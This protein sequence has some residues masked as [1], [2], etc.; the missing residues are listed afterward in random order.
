MQGTIYKSTGYYSDEEWQDKVLFYR[1]ENDMKDTPEQ[2]IIEAIYEDDELVYGEEKET[3]DKILDGKIL[4]IVDLGRWNGR[5]NGYKVLGNNLNEVMTNF[6]NDDM[7]VFCDGKD[8]RAEAMDHDGTSYFLFREIKDSAN[9]DRLL[10]AIY[11]NED[12]S[13][14]KLSYYTRSLAPYVNSAYGCND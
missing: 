13:R 1:T 7:H 11:N 14:Q 10:G 12:I 4:V 2:T 6:N 3:L 8:V 9:I 5:H